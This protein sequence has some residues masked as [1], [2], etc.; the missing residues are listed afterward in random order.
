MDIELQSMDG[1]H[2]VEKDRPAKLTKMSETTLT[3]SDR[4][5]SMN[6]IGLVP[7]DDA[8]IIETLLCDHE[9]E[10]D[11]FIPK[12][13]V[14]PSE[15]TKLLVCLHLY[16]SEQDSKV[17]SEFLTENDIFLQDP[18]KLRK[19]IKYKNPQAWVVPSNVQDMLNME[20]NRPAQEEFKRHENEIMTIFD[21]DTIPLAV[22]TDS[23]TTGPTARISPRITTPLLE[24]VIP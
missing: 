14:Q 8:Q 2:H 10:I 23:Q 12:A 16:G 5:R 20:L 6:Y 11:L 21:A 9:V 7:P 17:L 1:F 24:Y 4:T 15:P 22:S 13:D 18:V 19:A 3:I